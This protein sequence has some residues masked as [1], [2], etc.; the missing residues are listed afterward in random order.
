MITVFH[1]WSLVLAPIQQSICLSS[2]SLKLSMCLTALL[3]RFGINPLL[4]VN[5]VLTYFAVLVS[6]GLYSPSA[7]FNTSKSVTKIDKHIVV[8]IFSPLWLLPVNQRK[9]KS[10]V[11]YFEIFIKLMNLPRILWSLLLENLSH[12][13]CLTEGW[14]LCK[15]RQ[16]ECMSF[17]Q[18]FF[19]FFI[20]HSFVTF[21]K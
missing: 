6:Q 3:N 9:L 14:W 21:R 19:T 15:Y 10:Y 2:I 7:P 17:S 1:I 5:H 8:L 11:Q 18:G 13:S 4:K 12:M 20:S 16:D